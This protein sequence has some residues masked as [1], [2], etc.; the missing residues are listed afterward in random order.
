[1]TDM[2]AMLKLK[3]EGRHH[4]GIDDTRNIARCALQLMKD[5]KQFTS[6]DMSKVKPIKRSKYSK[7]QQKQQK[8]QSTQPADF[9]YI[10]ALDFEAQC[11]KDRRLKCQEIIEF[12]VIVIDIKQQKILDNFTFHQYIKP[13]VVPKITPFCTELTGIT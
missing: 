1:M 3:L 5:G 8:Q 10:F 13:V 9:D 6:K 4:S 2:L 11:V 12:P 7:N